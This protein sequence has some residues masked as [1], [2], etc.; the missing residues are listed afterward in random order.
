[1]PEGHTIHRLARQFNDVFSG[2]PVLASS[3][4]G[5]FSSGA[6][7]I[8]GRLLVSAHAHGKQ[9]FISFD[10]ELT[11]RVHLGLY[12]A[13]DFGGDESF[14]GAS[15]IGAPRR[16]GERELA[17]SDEG[18]CGP[19][20]PVGAVRLRLQTEHGWADLRGPSACELLTEQELVAQIAKLGPDP[21]RDAADAGQQFGRNVLAKKSASAIAG[22]LMDQSVVAGIGNI[23]RAELLFRNGID[24]WQ[25]GSSLQPGQVAALWADA[26][27]LLARGVQA[28]KIITTERAE[29]RSSGALNYVYQRQGERCLHCPQTVLMT[30]L[31]GRKLYYC[32]GCQQPGNS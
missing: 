31:A 6:E 17:A 2:Q 21:L 19:P 7:K 9:L 13:W 16:I 22:L 28:G 5:R 32:P 3:P 18:Y 8:D 14:R 20:A 30:E 11:L 4:Q 27:L 1:M 23:Y 26:V 25:P 10:H 29:Q 24:P 15:S 12:G